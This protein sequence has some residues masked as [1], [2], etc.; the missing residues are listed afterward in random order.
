MEKE[1]GEKMLSICKKFSFAAA[2]KLP[3]HNGL[4]KNLHGHEYVLEVEIRG[5]I[6]GDDTSPEKGMIMDFGELKSIVN[7]IIIT[8][9]DHTYLND[10]IDNPTAEIMVQQFAEKLQKEINDTKKY[11]CYRR[12]VRVRL[13][14]T[15]TSYAEWKL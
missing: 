12:I 13:Y 3:N 8:P 5:D 9:Y 15:P 4:C 10:S 1:M 6:N 2:H 14:E 11:G 7:N